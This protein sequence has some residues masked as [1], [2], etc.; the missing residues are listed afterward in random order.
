MQVRNYDAQDGSKRYVTEVIME[1]MDF[2]G[3]KGDNAG[4]NAGGFAG[5]FQAAAPS[6]APAQSSPAGSAG[7]GQ[8][9]PADD[10]I[11]F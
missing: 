7:F 2:V 5:G 6:G 9:M 3:S 10:D 1:N 4:G 8:A 11:P